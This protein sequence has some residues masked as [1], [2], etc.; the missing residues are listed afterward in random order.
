MRR[1]QLSARGLL[2]V[3][4]QVGKHRTKTISE[5]RNGRVDEHF[6]NGKTVGFSSHYSDGRHEYRKVKHPI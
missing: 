2:R 1:E 3:I 4:D 5:S 6:E